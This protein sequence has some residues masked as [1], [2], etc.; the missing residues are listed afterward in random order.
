M[1]MIK[2]HSSKE[3]PDDLLKELS[4]IV[5][6]TIG[7]PEKYVMVVTDTAA[8]MMSGSKG[9]AVYAEVKSIGGLSRVV[10]HEITMKI[11]VLLNDHL[12]IPQDRIYVTFQSVEPDHWGWNGS[13]FG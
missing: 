13:T 10:N 9:D 2:L 6:E 11:C 4:A 3:I 12:G 1:P 5:A 7:K 8:M